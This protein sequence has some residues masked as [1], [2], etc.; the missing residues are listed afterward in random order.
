MGKYSKIMVVLGACLLFGVG[1]ILGYQRMIYVDH[2]DEEVISMYEQEDIYQND[3]ISVDRITSNT[4]MIYEHFDRISGE[5]EVLEAFAPNFML[6]KNQ[7]DIEQTFSEWNVISFTEE[8]VV[9]RREVENR[10]SRLYTLGIQD[11]F[12]AIFHGAN[13]G[14]NL[15]ELTDIHAGRLPD[16]EIERLRE[17]VPVYT[18]DELIRRLEDYSS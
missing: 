16:E 8:E 11:D 4:R 1:G 18:Q 14:T 13:L 5:I 6:R 9:I 7:Q 15:K 2:E 17:G 3:N 10:I 12:I